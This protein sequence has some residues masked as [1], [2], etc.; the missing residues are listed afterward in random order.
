MF[1]D[2]N[3]LV[4][5]N[6]VLN[7]KAYG[8]LKENMSVSGEFLSISVEGMDYYVFNTLKIIDDKLINTDKALD[9]IELG[10]N[11]GLKNVSF[12]DDALEGAVLFKSNID[13]LVSS[14]CTEQFKDI[15]VINGLNGL[16]F[17][18]V[19]SL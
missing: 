8:V 15:L 17:E 12:Y 3:Y 10:V 16:V 6:L 19:V 18:E 4:T 2:P 14:Y 9:N 5:G 11:A 7:E 1:S 13:K